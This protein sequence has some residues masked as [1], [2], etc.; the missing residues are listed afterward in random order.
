MPHVF[1]VSI[2]FFL[3]QNYVYEVI[4]LQF[5]NAPE[6]WIVVKIEPLKKLEQLEL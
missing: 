6:T 2:C 5:V 4:E 3:L 1:A